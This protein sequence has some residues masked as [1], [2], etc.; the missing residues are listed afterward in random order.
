VNFGVIEPPIPAEMHA[1]PVDRALSEVATRQHGV[2]GRWQLVDLGLSRHAIRHRVAAGRLHALRPGVYSVGHRAVARE[3][4]WMA[5]VL[6]IGPDA[7]LSHRS[8]AALWGLRATS[9]SRVEVTVARPLRT[10]SGIQLH[11][12]KVPTDEVTVRIGIPVTTVP[13]TLVDLA[14]VLRTAD[15]RRAAEQAEALRLADPVPLKTVVQR[16]RGRH[17]A[18]RL[19]A[20]VDDGIE[21]T[22]TR[23][24][25]ERRFLSFIEEHGLPRPQVNVAM[26]VNGI[27][28]EADCVWR[29]QRTIVE[30]DGH[31]FHSDRHAFERDRE[32]DRLLQAA[33][34][35]VVRITWSQLHLQPA[36]VLRDLNELL[37]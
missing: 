2:V 35:R 26:E 17:G 30:L 10:R 14:A 11:R 21:A 29:A 1:T 19:R 4:W 5:A 3:G 6:A 22:I 9:Q 32:R 23:S 13:R 31:T 36:A 7:V 16:H 15:L 18:G 37:G 12:G 33:G 27:R 20:I 8:A 24:E 28:I 25:L 34:W